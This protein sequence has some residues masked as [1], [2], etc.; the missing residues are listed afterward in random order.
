M[1]R[2]AAEVSVVCA[3]QDAPAGARTEPGWRALEVAGPLAF[4]LVGILASLTQPLAA[5]G[6]SVFAIST[7]DTDYVLIRAG[8]LAAAID[9]L[10][11]AGH[12][13]HDA[14]PTWHMPLPTAE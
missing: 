5:A 12:D 8:A 14:S 2:T 11:E 3:L 1:T 13:V 10:R 6:V 9:A 4:S 7:F